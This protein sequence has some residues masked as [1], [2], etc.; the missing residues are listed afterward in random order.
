MTWSP[1]IASV[2]AQTVADQIEIVVVDNCSTDGTEEMFETPEYKDVR[3][4]RQGANLGRWR[5]MTAALAASTGQYVAMLFDDEVMEPEKPSSSRA[6]CSMAVLRRSPP[7]ELVQA[8]REW[9]ARGDRAAVDQALRGA[10]APARFRTFRQVPGW[11]VTLVIR[12]GRG[13][14]GRR[15]R[16]GRAVRRLARSSCASLPMDRSPTRRRRS[17][18]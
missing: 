7:L 14:P 8:L 16:V 18:R 3:Y 15:V 11:I 6:V 2:R 1:A 12:K 10:P 9:A 5:N 13:P 17:S 4:I